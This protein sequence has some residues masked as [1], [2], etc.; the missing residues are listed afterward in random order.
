LAADNKEDIRLQMDF[1]RMKYR[2][3]YKND[4]SKGV[5]GQ[6]FILWVD[7]CDLKVYSWCKV[8]YPDAIHSFSESSKLQ[9]CSP[10]IVIGVRGTN[11][12]E[13]I[14]AIS[15]S[16]DKLNTEGVI[17]TLNS[18]NQSKAPSNPQIHYTYHP[19]GYSDAYCPPTRFR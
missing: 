11:T 17:L 5:P 18:L 2:S 3:D 8:K 1:E 12:V 14:K 16:G 9:D 13:Q 15:L 10:G 19:V 6:L 7:T 4:L